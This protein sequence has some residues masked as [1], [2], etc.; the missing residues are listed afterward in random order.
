LALGG[1]RNEIVVKKHSIARG[2]LAAVRTT[3]PIS[4]SVD[5]KISQSRQS[6]Q[7]TKVESASNVAQNPLESREVRLTG[8]VHMKADLLHSVC[9]IWRVNIKYCRAPTRLRKSEAS[10]TGAPSAAATFGLVSTGVEHAL[11]SA[12]PTR[13]RISSINCH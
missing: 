4:I 12:I 9:N 13:S 10:D 1:P 8:V 6:Q 11:H 2:G 5:N 7:E 3:S